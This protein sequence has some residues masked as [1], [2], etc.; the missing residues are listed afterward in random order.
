[1]PKPCQPCVSAR[2][3]PHYRF[4]QHLVHPEH[5]KPMVFDVRGEAL[6]LGC[7]A[8]WRRLSNDVELI[9]LGQV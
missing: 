7:G 2:D 1:M 8:T 6:C 5:H 3:D 9:R 4:P